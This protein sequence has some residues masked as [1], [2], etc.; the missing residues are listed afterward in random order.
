M[1]GTTLVRNVM[2]LNAMTLRPEQ[3]I[4]DA[5]DILA[6][7][8]FGGMPVVDGSGHLLGLLRDEDLIVSEARVHVPTFITLLGATIPVPGTMH[9]LEEELHKFAGAT[10]E[11]VMD[12]ECPTIG[13]DD[14]LEDLASMMWEHDVTHVPVI[15]NDRKVLGIVARGD[16][17]RFIARTT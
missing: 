15:D 2:T 6:E 10:V 7:H 8:R 11:D 16:L 14:T 13:P 4:T 3:A 12:K 1:P 17:V 5:A 9:H